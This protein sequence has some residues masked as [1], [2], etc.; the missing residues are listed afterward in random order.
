MLKSFSWQ[1]FLLA[2]TLL[3]LLWYAVVWLFYRKKGTQSSAPLPHS[4][5]DDF[6]PLDDDNL[7]GK[8]ALEH[9]VSIVEADDFSFAESENIREQ[10][11]QLE[12]LGDIADVQQE[13]K[14][15]CGILASED[16][17][18]DDFFSL[19]EVIRNKYPKLASSSLLPEL[20]EFIREHVPF[21]LT[22]EELDQLWA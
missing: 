9:G 13:I 1:D 3:T 16:G 11:D 8:S 7:M 22:E 10:P 21:H 14:A 5:E 12:K 6:D 17:T 2:A 18:K 20:N 4:W 15:I 19:F